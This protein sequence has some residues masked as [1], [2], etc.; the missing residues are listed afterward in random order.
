MDQCASK[1][2]LVLSCMLVVYCSFSARSETVTPLA[3]IPEHTAITRYEGTRTCV[4]C[5]EVEAL[6]MITSAH[7]QWTGMAPYVTN[8]QGKVGKGDRE[9]NTYCG[10]VI[11]SRRIACWSCHAGLGK[12][13]TGELNMEQINNIDCL[14]CH[15]QMYKR[16]AVPPYPSADINLDRYVNVNDLALLSLEWLKSGC[17]PMTG[18]NNTDLAGGGSINLLDFQILAMEWLTCTDPAGSCL[19]QWT[20]TLTY[21]DYRGISHSWTL[22]VEDENGDFQYG[23]DEAAMVIDIVQAAQTV[24][25]PTRETCLRCHAYAAGTDC[26]KRGDLGTASVS[27]PVEVDIHMSEQG[28]NFSCQRCHNSVEHKILGRGLD[29][30]PSERMEIMTCL[31]GGCH[32]SAP[33]SNSRLDTHTSRVACQTCHI[34]TFAKLNST[35]VERDWTHPNWAQGLFGGQGGYKPEE[36]RDMLLIPAYQWY[37]GTSRVYVLGEVATLNANGQYEFGA[38]NGDVASPGAQLYPMKEHISN[39]ARHDATGVIIPHSTSEFFFTGDFS[40]AVEKGMELS[41][42]Q[43]S[44]TLVQIH[45]FQTINHGVEPT[46]NALKCGQCHESYSGGPERMNL[47]ALGYVLKGNA[48]VVCTQCHDPEESKPFDTIHKKH[49]SDKKYDCSWCHTFSRPERNLTMP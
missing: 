14:M 4:Q 40:R 22:P 11:T 10:T 36:I 25:L 13:P 15:S 39:S 48:S 32:S 35:E 38:P 23:P 47:Q 7:Y 37:D 41:G 26:G 21:L 27:P 16:K 45:T 8:V 12:T 18:C 2:R 44:W 24:H 46:Y 3:I 20:E 33:H 6:E 5:H 17:T 29:I 49:V 19:F 9:F 43:G 31:S 1:S 42:M 30:R 34:P 28:L